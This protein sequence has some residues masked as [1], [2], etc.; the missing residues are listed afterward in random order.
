MRKTAAQKA[1]EATDKLIEQTWYRMASGV[2][3]SIM[4][5]PAIFR[6]CATEMANGLAVEVAVAQAMAA[7]RKN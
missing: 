3:V 6:F 7:W 5:I 4:D 1:H 2:Q